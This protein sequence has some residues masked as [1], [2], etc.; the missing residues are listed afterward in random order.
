MTEIPLIL[1]VAPRSGNCHKVE[2][3]LS[4]L[5]V[6]YRTATH[7]YTPADLKSQAFRA[8]NPRGQ[9]PVLEIGDNVIWDSQAILVYLA[10]AHGGEGWLPSDAAAMAEVMQ[11]LALSA[12]EHL[13]GLAQVRIM[14]RYR[15]G[16]EPLVLTVLERALAL[17]ARGLETME[18]RLAR[19]PWLALDR[20]TI[21][22]MACFTYPALHRE[23]EI[24]LA[25]YPATRAWLGRVRALPGFKTMEGID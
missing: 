17:A 12:N 24:D 18:R 8:K 9:V 21:A 4:I 3:F 11:W 16:N 15:H 25:P 5:G 22:E 2:L 23:V 1:H 7:D 13:F 14:R 19:A 20:P 10:R 6:P